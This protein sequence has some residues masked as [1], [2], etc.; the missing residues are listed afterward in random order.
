MKTYWTEKGNG[1]QPDSHMDVVAGSIVVAVAPNATRYKVTYG[2]GNTDEYAI[3]AAGAGPPVESSS[4]GAAASFAWAKRSHVYH[5]ANCPVVKEIKPENLVFGDT[6]P[7]GRTKHKCPDQTQMPGSEL[8]S[9]VII[10]IGEAK[11]VARFDWA[12]MASFS[13]QQQVKRGGGRA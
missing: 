4:S 7:G 5:D 8:R 6:P 10:A 13:N 2:N 1:A 3:A 12:H 9:L 11:G